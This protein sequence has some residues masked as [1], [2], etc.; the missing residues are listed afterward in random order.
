MVQVNLPW[1]FYLQQSKSHFS[2]NSGRAKMEK[3]Y[4]VGYTNII[5]REF[6]DYLG[7]ESMPKL[8]WQDNL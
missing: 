1:D 7:D 8:T 6:R 5:L 4:V 2:L 3:S